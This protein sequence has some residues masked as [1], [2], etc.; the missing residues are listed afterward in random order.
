MTPAQR[1]AV[2]KRMKAYWRKMRKAGTTSMASR[3]AS[4]RNR[5]LDLTINWREAPDGFDPKAA[6]G[7]VGKSP[8]GSPQ[9]EVPSPIPGHVEQ[10]LKSDAAADEK[11]LSLLIEL[12]FDDMRAA[13]A[14]TYAYARVGVTVQPTTQ[15][16]RRVLVQ[17]ASNL[18]RRERA[19]VIEIIH[20]WAR[21]YSDR[22]PQDLI[23]VLQQ[24]VKR[25]RGAADRTIVD[26]TAV[27]H[28][29]KEDKDGYDG[30]F[31]PFR[32]DISHAYP[33]TAE[34]STELYL[35]E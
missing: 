4:R 30:D 26:N 23:F 2:S 20:A 5:P 35:A 29:E 18:L 10:S 15:A 6:T 7:G 32:K 17:L 14:A 31:V 11:S 21:T 33:E 34:V 3:R 16:E 22:V 9:T 19:A 25:V 28:Y 24:L 8:L 27:G 13:R 12:A 1:K